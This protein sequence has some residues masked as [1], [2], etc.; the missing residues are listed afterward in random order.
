LSPES[1]PLFAQPY[2][3]RDYVAQCIRRLRPFEPDVVHLH[4]FANHIPAYRRAFPNAVIVLH[5]HCDWL[6]E[7]D[8]AETARCL[9][10]ADLVV[11]CS[12]HV[13]NGA[14]DR[15]ANL[16]VRFAMLPNGVNVT[17]DRVTSSATSEVVLFVGRVSPEKGVHLL[18][19]AWPLVRAARPTAELQ[20]VGPMA[21][22]PRELLVDIS[23]DPEVRA[24]ARFY[25]GDAREGGT[26]E[27]QL[28]AMVPKALA[29]SVTF[30]GFEPHERILQR[31]PEATLLVNPSLSEA[32][33]MSL[34]E[35][36]AVGTPVIASRVGG[37]EEIVRRT[38]GGR[39]V[40][41]ADADAL[42]CALIDL[43]ANSAVRE[44]MGRLGR[45]R[46][47]ELYSWDR[48]SEQAER[49]YSRCFVG[50]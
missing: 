30:A 20:I 35:A 27:Q 39:L 42:A 11:G 45:E 18:L 23:T 38:E 1:P 10:A 25:P 8:R 6:V 12:E 29:S 46:V 33:G 50:V 22:C 17:A 14:R 19:E 21:V 16:P 2:Y 5:M 32:F 36:L 44:N 3:L 28:R 4:N 48:V 24:L 7:L 15:F 43:L 41:K 49:V 47:V 40:D 34:I 37:M 31:Y 26:Y 9:S 13:V